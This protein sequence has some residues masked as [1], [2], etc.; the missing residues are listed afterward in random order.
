[1][2][3][4]PGRTTETSR[5]YAGR[6]LKNVGVVDEYLSGVDLADRDALARVYAIAV[7]VVPEAEQ[8]IRYAMAA[9]V[10]R[11]KGLVATV[12]RTKFLS[13]YPFSGAV[14]GSV[15]E[16]LSE[17][18]TTSGSIHYAADHEL[19]DDLM[20]RIIQRRRTEI[21]ATAG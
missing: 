14:I 20:R 8:G 6:S 15:L 19:P 9:L 16:E 21:D 7:E 17:F 13:L 18:E 10:Y 5:E 3:R 2:R 1:M 4:R 11:D 12:R